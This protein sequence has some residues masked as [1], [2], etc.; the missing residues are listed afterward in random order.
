MSKARTAKTQFGVRNRTVSGAK[1][2]RVGTGT[3]GGTALRASTRDAG[4][5]N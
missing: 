4:N 1:E 5:P 3:G 2:E